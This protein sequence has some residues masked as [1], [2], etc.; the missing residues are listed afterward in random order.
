MIRTIYHSIKNTVSRN[1][2]ATI[3]SRHMGVNRAFDFKSAAG[4]QYATDGKGNHAVQTTT[5]CDQADCEIKKCVSPCGQLEKIEIEGNYTHKPP[6][7]LKYVFLDNTD[8]QGN[9][10]DQYFVKA[11]KKPQISVEEMKQLTEFDMAPNKAAS[12]FALQGDILDK[13]K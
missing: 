10:N 3:P 1:V 4:K 2:Q 6:S 12:D 5:Y 7:G 13:I 11:T 8:Y 9:K